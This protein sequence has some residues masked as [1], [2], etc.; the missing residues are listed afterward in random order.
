MTDGLPPLVEVRRLVKRYGDKIVL[1]GIDLVIERGETIVLIG[2]SGSGKSTLARILVGLEQPTS[3]DILVEGVPLRSMRR[4]AL[5]EARARFGMV[6][7]K[8]ALLDSLTV[9][10]NVAFPLREH[11]HLDADETRARVMAALD[12]LGV[13]GAAEKLPGELSG[14]MAKRVAIAR[15]TVH[16][17]EVL[18]YDEPTSGLDPISSRIVDGLIERMREHH[19]VTSIVITHDMLTAYDVADR[20]LLLAGGKLVVDGPPEVVF[21]SHDKDIQPFAMSSGLDL[22]S[23]GAR[24]A[25]KTAAEI[26]TLWQLR[27]RG[28]AAPLPVAV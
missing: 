23:L 8:H 27:E 5:R 22:S 19:F 6:F 16:E 7:Q 3:G 17:P 2:G 15:A 18:V 1:D 9:F 10:E 21:R 11:E 14:G 25:R 26:R 24:A 12:E 20:V 28:G 13:A 4:R